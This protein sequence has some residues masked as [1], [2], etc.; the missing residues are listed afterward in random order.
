MATDPFRRQFG[1]TK[2]AP[3]PATRPPSKKPPPTSGSFTPA[4]HLPLQ[5]TKPTRRPGVRFD[6]PSFARWMYKGT[7]G[8]DIGQSYQQQKTAGK[9]VERT[10]L[11]WG[12]LLFFAGDEHVGIYIDG[13]MFLQTPKTGDVIKVSPLAG[14]ADFVEARRIFTPPR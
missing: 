7:Y 6:V 11:Q 3:P 9:A 10:N 1:A 8:I 13:G 12:D 5:L 14:R 2:P 4:T